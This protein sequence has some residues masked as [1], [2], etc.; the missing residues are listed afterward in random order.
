MMNNKPKDKKAGLG[1]IRVGDT[2]IEQEKSKKLLGV[3]IEESQGWKEHFTGKKSLISSLN[4]RLFAMRSVV[5]FDQ[6]LCAAHSKCW[7]K[8]SFLR[9]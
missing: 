1:K 4:K 9:I 6:H 5:Y 8:S 7:T 2:M 3:T